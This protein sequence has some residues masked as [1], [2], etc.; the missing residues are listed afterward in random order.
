MQRDPARTSK[1]PNP[2]PHHQTQAPTFHSIIVA[3]HGSGPPPKHSAVPAPCH[4]RSSLPTDKLATFAHAISNTPSDRREHRIQQPP[5]FFIN[6]LGFH[7]R[8]DNRQYL[9]VVVGV[10]LGQA[11]R[12]GGKLRLRTSV[13]GYPF[14]HSAE[15][16]KAGTVTPAQRHRDSHPV[17]STDRVCSGKR[18]SGGMTPITVAGAALTLIDFP[19]ISGS[20]AY[21]CS[22]T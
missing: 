4:A 8:L 22:H 14:H 7:P 17:A 19:M 9:F 6:E 2:T 3:T 11:I 5:R 21:R 1:A 16:G 15:H 12:Y 18:K 13:S 20:P 10:F